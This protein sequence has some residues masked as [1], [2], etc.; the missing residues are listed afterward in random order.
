MS[1][2]DNLIFK[3]RV[4]SRGL[5]NLGGGEGGWGRSCPQAPMFL[6]IYTMSYHLSLLIQN[7]V[8]RMDVTL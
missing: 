7:G 3:K 4:K 2:K 1:Q 6:I 8:L 5:F